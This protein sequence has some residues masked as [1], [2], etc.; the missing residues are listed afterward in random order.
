MRSEYCIILAVLGWGIGSLLYKPATN[1]LHPIVIF[2][3]TM[4]AYMIVNVILWLTVK[5]DHTVTLAGSIYAFIGSIFMCL[6]TLGFALLLRSGD[7]VGHAI[8]LTSLYPALTLVLSAIFFGETLTLIRGIGIV[9][10]LI[11]FALLS[12]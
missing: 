11:S 4:L 6:G 2:A 9:F 8:I 5:F 7:D 3:F 1:T 12:H 10:A